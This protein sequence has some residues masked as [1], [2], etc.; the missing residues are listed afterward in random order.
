[1]SI[2]CRLKSKRRKGEKWVWSQMIKMIPTHGN[3][4]EAAYG[5]KPTPSELSSG[6]SVCLQLILPST[7]SSQQ[8]TCCTV[9]KEEEKIN[10]ISL[11]SRD[12]HILSL[13]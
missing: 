5:P 13:R 1:M 12:P 3:R 7:K 8:C 11:V 10:P 9:G 6:D 2:I 4:Q